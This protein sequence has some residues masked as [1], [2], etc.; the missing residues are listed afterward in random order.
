MKRRKTYLFNAVVMVL[1]PLLEVALL[2]LMLLLLLVVLLRLLLLV[3]LLLLKRLVAVLAVMRLTRRR[4]RYRL[5]F[6]GKRGAVKKGGMRRGR[7]GGR[8]WRGAEVWYG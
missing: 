8:L 3:L 6:L 2:L 4:G 5:L 1:L 7:S